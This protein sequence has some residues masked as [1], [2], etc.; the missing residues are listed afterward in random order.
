[1]F[2][3]GL[4]L[5]SKGNIINK[6]PD[7]NSA[8]L[9][10]SMTVHVIKAPIYRQSTTSLSRS[11][12]YPVLTQQYEFDSYLYHFLITFNKVA[13]WAKIILKEM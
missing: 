3:L 5:N 12:G 2:D 6:G 13:K 7:L 9:Y 11:S 1:M 4:P 10:L 8:H